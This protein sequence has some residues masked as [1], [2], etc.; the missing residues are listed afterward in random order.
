M[1]EDEVP[2]GYVHSVTLRLVPGADERAPGGAVTMALCG[3]W[4]HEGVCR[5]PHHTSI[6]R[7][8]EV[9]VARVVFSAWASEAED[10]RER[11]ERSLREGADWDIVESG[12]ADPTADEVALAIRWAYRR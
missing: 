5:W 1:A 11:I 3:H 9:H 4:E 7:L 8:G 10:V 6:E 12:A 2:G